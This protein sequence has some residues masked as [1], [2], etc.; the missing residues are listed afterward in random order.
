MGLYCGMNYTGGKVGG[1]DTS[2]RGENPHDEACRLHDIDYGSKGKVPTWLADFKLAARTKELN[3][4]MEFDRLSWPEQAYVLAVPPLFGWK[5]LLD[6]IPRTMF[7][8]MD[9]GTGS[10]SGSS[11]RKVIK[12]TGATHERHRKPYSNASRKAVKL[13]GKRRVPQIFG[14]RH[15]EYP[16]DY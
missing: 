7:G 6:F 13:D 15:H 12:L 4:T 2:I 3:K 8:P 10:G 5:G 14:A 11:K 1:R 16:S 9:D